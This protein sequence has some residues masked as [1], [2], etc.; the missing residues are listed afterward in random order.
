MLDE[1]VWAEIKVAGE[2]LRLFRNIM[3]KASKRRST[4]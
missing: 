4:T 2:H 3:R 1:G